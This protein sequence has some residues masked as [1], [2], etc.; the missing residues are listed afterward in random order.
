MSCWRHKC[1]YGLSRNLPQEN[2][3]SEQILPAQGYVCEESLWYWPRHTCM[4]GLLWQ[5]WTSH[6]AC[7]TM[8]AWSKPFRSCRTPS[9]LTLRHKLHERFALSSYTIQ[10]EMKQD[11]LLTRP[12]V[13]QTNLSLG[14]GIYVQCLASWKCCLLSV[15]TAIPFARYSIC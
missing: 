6:S 2:L 3:W 13:I 10:Q 14:C 4:P 9:L 11:I 1:A 5:Q 7:S 12:W 15:I 8:C